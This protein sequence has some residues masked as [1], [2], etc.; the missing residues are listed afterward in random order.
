[1]KFLFKI[2]FKIK[3]IP[4]IHQFNP[5]LSLTL[6]RIPQ[7]FQITPINKKNTN[8]RMKNPKS[9]KHNNSPKLTIN[10]PPNNI[11]KKRSKIIITKSQN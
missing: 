2:N 3:L 6:P 9:M 5:F 11:P 1:M 4:N 8:K 7:T 10:K